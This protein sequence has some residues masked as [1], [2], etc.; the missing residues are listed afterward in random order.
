[1]SEKSDQSTSVHGDVLRATASANDDLICIIDSDGELSHWNQ[2]LETVTGYSTAELETMAPAALVAE[3]ERRAFQETV[4]KIRDTGD[5]RVETRLCTA[6][7][8]RIAYEFRGAVIGDDNTE[9]ALVAHDITHR[10][11]GSAERRAI[12]GRMTDAFFAL[13]EDWTF[14]YVNEQAEPILA[15]AMGE[16]RTAAEMIGM[17]I[18]DAIP[19]AVDS[20]FYDAYH[21]AMNTQEL[22]TIEEYYEPIDTWFEV[23]AY[24]S[25]TGL[26]VFFRDVTEQRQ[27][28]EQLA[29]QQ[30]YLRR[31]YD[32]TA[33]T[34]LS[35]TEQTEALLALGAEV[36]D[37]EYGTLS[38]IRGDE[39]NF[40]VVHAPDDSIQ[41]GD[42]IP[43]RA[44]NCERTA[45]TAETVVLANVA[46]DAPEL[47]DKAGYTDMGIACYLGAPVIVDGE[48]YGT[49]CL[50]D[51]EPR[52]DSFTDWEITLV[53]LMAQWV[54]YELTNRQRRAK[55][56]R[57]NKQLEEFASIVSHDLRN[58]LNVLIGSLDALG[59]DEDPE[60]LERCQRAVER[61]ESLIED[62]LTL[63]RTGQQI[64]EL[65]AIA[66]G[67]FMEDCWEIISH[68]DA[69][70]DIV[71][72]GTIQADPGRL[73]QLVENLFRNAVEHGGDAITVTVRVE[74]N[75]FSIADNGSGIPEAERDNVLDAGYSTAQDGTGFGLSIVRQVADAHGWDV[76]VG[77]SDS[78]G[79][80]FAVT[81]VDTEPSD[82]DC[83]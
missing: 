34:E 77:E 22:V 58:P 61:M 8:D 31:M 74:D 71:D 49:F 44:T 62:L 38:Q 25:E 1:M 15:N 14:T 7:G 41:A 39:Y 65:E 59:G 50:Y 60:A 32:V 4:A 21:D 27:Q 45:A 30:R 46:E 40:E 66:V 11:H 48:V 37:T 35:F 73:R 43:L 26:S 2:C 55:L 68:E 36:L 16:D 72:D 13:D 51:R 81:G 64:S 78:G 17:D 33:D 12:L 42:T 19:E 67:P 63:A 29:R 79:A 3:S 10:S 76:T 83:P 82:A 70:L 75:G 9:V 6:D 53:D 54:S 28:T 57:Q 80:H 23:R 20:P 52:A 24:P 18:W 69:S 56:E 5:G 47:T